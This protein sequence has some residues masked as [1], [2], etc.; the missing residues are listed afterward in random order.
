MTTLAVAE[1]TIYST[2]VADWSETNDDDTVVPIEYDN[3]K[4][5]PPTEANWVRLTIRHN[6]GTQKSLGGIGNRKFLRAG[7]VFVQCFTP[8]NSGATG[9]RTLAAAARTIFEGKTLSPG[10]ISFTDVV[11]REVGPDEGWY[12]VNV[13]AAFDYDET[14]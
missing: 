4:I 3:E 9:A 12:Q 13:E 14:L 10:S 8:E 7:I 11:V 2:F 5:V 1:E 6:T